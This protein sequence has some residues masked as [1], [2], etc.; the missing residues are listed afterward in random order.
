M[1]LFRNR[2]SVYRNRDVLLNIEKKK[3]HSYKHGKLEVEH[4]VGQYIQTLDIGI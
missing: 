1:G 3:I 2:I 4:R